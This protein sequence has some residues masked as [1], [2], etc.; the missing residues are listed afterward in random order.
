MAPLCKD[1]H[2]L[3]IE[4]SESIARK[5]RHDLPQILCPGKQP[6]QLCLHVVLSECNMYLLFT[7]LIAP[8]HTEPCIL[9]QLGPL[10]NLAKA[11]LQF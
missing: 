7:Q 6:D 4:V 9:L 3:S 11:L 8:S 1:L 2:P 5:M 10:L